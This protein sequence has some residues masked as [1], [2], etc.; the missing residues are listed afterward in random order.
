MLDYASKSYRKIME[1]EQE[2]MKEV[3]EISKKILKDL[4]KEA[5]KNGC[6]ADISSKVLEKGEGGAKQ[7]IADYVAKH[8]PACLVVSS[9]G[10]GAVGR[11]LVGSVSDF[12]VHNAICPVIVVRKQD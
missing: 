10:A 9:R 1:L 5:E 7:T 4:R 12:L 3:K 2:F 6:K 8:R 11:A